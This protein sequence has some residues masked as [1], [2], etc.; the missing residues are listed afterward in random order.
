MPARSCRRTLLFLIVAATA[1]PA[2]SAQEPGQTLSQLYHTAWTVR[3]GAPAAVEA[4][5]QTADGFLWLGSGTG[6]TRFDGVRFE[7]YEPPADQSMPSTN[8]SALAAARDSGL[9][10]GYRFGGVS[11]I[12]RDTIH[13]YGERDGLPLGTVVTVVEDSE[14]TTWVGTTSALARLEGE[15]WR[16]VGPDDGLAEGAVTAILA[17]R[18]RRLWVSAE[19]GV[20]MRAAGATRFERIGPP[21]SSA[22]GSRIYSFLQEAPD[23]TIWG[24]SQDRGLRMVSSA[25]EIRKDAVCAERSRVDGDRDRSERRDVDRTSS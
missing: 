19:A 6:L 21:L 8:V 1:A 9:W 3:E 20:F 16:T 23:G 17:D 10:V 13:S 24:S 2:A 22:G 15:R 11:L 5:T 25:G 7:L 18:N 4:L 14:G 12:R